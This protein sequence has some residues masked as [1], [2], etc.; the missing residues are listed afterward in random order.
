LKIHIKND[1]S[2]FMERTM[3]AGRASR[4]AEYNALFRAL[5]TV[6]PVCDRIVD[7]QLAASFL[8][9][10]LRAVAMLSRSAKISVAVAAYIDRR[11][12]GVM[13]SV[14]ARTRMIDDHLEAALR[15]GIRQI[16]VLGAGFDTRA[17]RIS[18]IDGARVFEVDHPDTGA[19]K[20]R[21][22][23]RALGTL[24]LHVSFT[25]V[26]F[27]RDDLEARLQKAGFDPETRTFFIWEGVSNYLTEAAVNSMLG[28]MG[29]SADG[30]RI[31]FT[32]VHRDVINDPSRFAGGEKLYR[33]LTKLQE[34]QTFGLDP[35]DVS[36][37]IA[38]HGLRLIEDIGSVDYRIR[39]LQGRAGQPRGHEFYRV[40]VAH[41]VRPD[42]SG[43]GPAQ[44]QG[45][46]SH[47]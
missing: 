8:S 31:V 46:G 9:R 41:V 26:D 42:T 37:F 32:Y 23:Q 40:A 3:K 39:Y 44:G 27:S 45:A 20:R 22:L 13:A 38:K 16:V 33:R 19:M 6:R 21:N 43:A 24:P 34:Q 2:F 29:R 5:E 15:E 18:G 14:I 28:F 35:A 25:A 10:P 1:H 17:Y 30:S 4:T 11:Q 47:S 36:K 7:D 12:P